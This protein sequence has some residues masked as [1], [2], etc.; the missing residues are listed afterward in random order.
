MTDIEL[1]I[2]CIIGKAAP[3]ANTIVATNMNGDDKINMIDV[4][5]TINMVIGKMD[6]SVILRNSNLKDPIYDTT[7]GTGMNYSNKFTYEAEMR[8]RGFF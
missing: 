3:N 4:Q 2:N 6:G 1:M 8:V 5:L 7:S